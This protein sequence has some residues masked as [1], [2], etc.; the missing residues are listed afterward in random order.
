MV[1]GAVVGEE[2]IVEGGRGDI[3]GFVLSGVIV[4]A[5]EAVVGGLVAVGRS[6]L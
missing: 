6:R 2:M 1:V 4:V 5:G 3:A